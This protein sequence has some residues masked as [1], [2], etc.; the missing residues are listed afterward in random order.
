M[1]RVEWE[2]SERLPRVLPLTSKS[3]APSVVVWVLIAVVL[4]I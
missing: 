1:R 3:V 4:T 2:G